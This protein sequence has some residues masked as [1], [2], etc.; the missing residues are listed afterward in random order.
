M[1]T[2]TEPPESPLGRALAK[3]SGGDIDGAIELLLAAA[4]ESLADAN[5]AVT[6]GKML[7]ETGQYERADPWFRHAMK[8]APD[9]VVVRMGYGAFLGEVGQFEEARKLL[10]GVLREVRVMLG[11][12]AP[13]ERAGLVGLEGF[14]ASTEINLARAAFEAGDSALARERVAPWLADADHWPSAHAVLADIVDRDGLDPTQVAEVG[15]ASG[16][17][18][19][20][21]V[22]HLLERIVDAEPCD[23]G[24]LEGVVARADGCFAFD[25][26]GVEPPLVEVF[27]RA[28]ELFAHAVMRGVV[29]AATCPRL[30][31]LVAHPAAAMDGDANEVED[32]ATAVSDDEG[33]DEGE[34]EHDI[35]VD[36][37]NRSVEALARAFICH[38]ASVRDRIAV[39]E[40]CRGDGGRGLRVCLS[41][42]RV[43][44]RW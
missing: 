3:R 23:F 40:R 21:M 12:A 18:S 10:G 20:Y 16:H 25:W 15:L 17:V 28:R 35:D 33:E 41:P 6:L 37:K 5:L 7:A 43:R 9:D 39:R 24:T 38:W 4:G 29:A 32:A 1:T 14:I 31:A 30:A 8:L 34:D 26:K 11:S 13:E 36:E 44:D 22:C 19:P 42:G 2:F 27:A